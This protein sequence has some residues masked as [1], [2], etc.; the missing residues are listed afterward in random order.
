MLALLMRN[1][2]GYLYIYGWVGIIALIFVM[3][4]VIL[5]MPDQYGHDK[6]TLILLLFLCVALQTVTDWLSFRKRRHW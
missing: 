1:V 5:K 6:V 2:F 3:E 4:Y